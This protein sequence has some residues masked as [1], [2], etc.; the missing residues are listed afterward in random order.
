MKKILMFVCTAMLFAAC[1][2]QKNVDRSATGAKAQEEEVNRPC[3]E[4]RTD[5]TAMRAT[6]N[7]IS[8]NMQNATDKALLAARRELATSAQTFVQRVAEQYAQSYEVNDKADFGSRTQDMTKLVAAKLMQGSTICC[9]EMIKKSGADGSVMYQAYVAVEIE[10][11]DLYKEIEKEA[12][13]TIGNSEKEK[14]DFNADEF[15]KI[16]DQEFGK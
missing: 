1:A 10:K 14:L 2:S 6:G 12:K 7:A 13:N 4:F 11:E 3:V 8:P 9:D 5:K 15:R 16:F